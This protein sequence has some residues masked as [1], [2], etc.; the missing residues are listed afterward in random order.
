MNK[1]KN[2]R[3]KTSRRDLPSA[4]GRR[5]AKKWRFPF[6]GLLGLAI[7]SGGG[8]AGVWYGMPGKADLRASLRF[9]K[10]DQLSGRDR[11]N[12]EKA[13]HAAMESNDFR[14]RAQETYETALHGHRDDGFLYRE[15]VEFFSIADASHSE[16]DRLIFDRKE[17]RDP[18]GDRLRL[19]AVLKALYAADAAMLTEAESH[20]K[21]VD[22]ERGE[23]AAAEQKLAELQKRID[24]GQKRQA[25]FDLARR[26]EKELSDQS[27]KLEKAWS[28][29]KRRDAKDARRTGCA[30]SRPGSG[31]GLD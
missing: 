26:N 31:P 21:A 25:N 8:A 1:P 16:G 13:Q 28:D 12:F 14:K 27:A 11:A 18:E 4:P 5:K 2:R 9:E 30:R 10:L 7:V 20:L 23:L 15:A 17:S 6:F 29:A 19:Q 3:H 22:G 24:D